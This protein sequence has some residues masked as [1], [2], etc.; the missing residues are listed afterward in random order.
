MSEKE[1]LEG[2]FSIVRK[3][4]QGAFLNTVKIRISVT[5]GE[6]HFD[7]EF[8][9]SQLLGTEMREADG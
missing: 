7:V 5:V 9:P 8:V 2:S 6:G 3:Q 4:N 1:I